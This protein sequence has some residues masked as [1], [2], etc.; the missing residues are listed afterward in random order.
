MKLTVAIGWFL[1]VS[2]CAAILAMS[3]LAAEGR[4]RKQAAATEQ[5]PLH[6]T[7]LL[8]VDP[9]DS[10][11]RIKDRMRSFFS[12]EGLDVSS[13]EQRQM[14]IAHKVDALFAADN[15]TSNESPKV[16][17]EFRQDTSLDSFRM[18]LLS[19]ELA[20]QSDE[21]C[22][23]DCPF[24]DLDEDSLH[25]HLTAPTGGPGDTVLVL[26]IRKSHDSPEGGR[27]VSALSL[28]RDWVKRAHESG[29]RPA[30]VRL[31]GLRVTLRDT[32]R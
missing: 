17:F 13:S 25:V 26:R 29:V 1:P 24:R 16:F 6:G 7:G 15:A 14:E 32:E 22:P 23:E 9:R 4:T 19:S 31:F 28:R 21:V 2:I 12:F 27:L 20:R 11:E 10:Q 8:I 5:S 30:G 18:S 3:T